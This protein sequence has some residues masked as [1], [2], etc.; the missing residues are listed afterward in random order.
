MTS[1]RA[2]ILIAEDEDGIRNSVERLLRLEGY[3]V[4]ACANGQVAL[5][6]AELHLP[7]VLV[8]DIHMPEMD[9]FALLDAIRARSALADCS[10]IMLTAAEDR[11]NMRRGMTTG[12][13]DYITKP[14]RREELL[15]SIC[16]QL[17]K[18]EQVR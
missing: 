11:A 13:D 15:D 18:R 4:I 8:T 17:K 6:Q 5:A 16:A 14:F 2:R 1:Y 3:E 10:V 12:A 9:G 7:Q